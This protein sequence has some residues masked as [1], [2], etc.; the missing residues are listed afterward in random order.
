MFFKHNIIVNEEEEHIN[1]KKNLFVVY[2]VE[3]HKK[4]NK[5]ASFLLYLFTFL[6][7]NIKFW[8]LFRNWPIYSKE[9]IT[10]IKTNNIGAISQGSLLYST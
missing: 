9:Y 4:S 8:T 3:K 6:T 2:D 1:Y 5:I 7:E 10:Y